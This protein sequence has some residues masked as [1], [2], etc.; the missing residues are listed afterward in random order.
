[1]GRISFGGSI[2]SKPIMAGGTPWKVVYFPKGF[3]VIVVDL[4]EVSLKSSQDPDY[5]SLYIMN[6]EVIFRSQHV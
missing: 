1:M 5:A 6:D 2:V 4:R 3:T